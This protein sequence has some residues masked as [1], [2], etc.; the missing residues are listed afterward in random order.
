M[1][2]TFVAF[3]PA[4]TAAMISRATSTVTCSTTA[5]CE[6]ISNSNAGFAVL[7]NSVGS[8]G[9]V[10]R[11]VNSNGVTGSTAA[12]GSKSGVVGYDNSN[13]ASTTNSGVLGTSP[14]GNGVQGMSQQGTGV[15]GVSVAASGIRGFSTSG[16]GLAGF[17]T[18]GAGGFFQSGTYGVL[19][20]SSET[21]IY[22]DATGPSP[23]NAV[24][25]VAGGINGVLV[26][27]NASSGH[28]VVSIDNAGNEIL[29]GTLTQSGQPMI[30][31]TTSSGHTVAAYSAR[32]SSPTLEDFGEAQLSNGQA[33]VALD[34][35]FGATIDQHAKYMV[36][37]SPQG[38]NRGL[39]VTQISGRGFAIRE[40]N[41]GHS[42]L[43]F[44]YRIVAKP[45]DTNAARLL[46][47]TAFSGL[48]QGR[49]LLQM[50]KALR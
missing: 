28:D 47:T 41:G 26:G 6:T 40:S 13:P 18:S 15:Q 2:F 14:A 36:F 3:H 8:V 30:R 33:F 12:S 34:P 31:T 10:G 37:V 20:F 21:A 4:Q 9:L 46:P 42:T 39:Y 23:G 43:A 7:A 32:T 45:Y 48:V 50:P 49:K 22:A 16:S 5:A 24:M 1:A 44:D 38:D 11:S 17:S 35:T 27:V 25:A 29:A 19:T